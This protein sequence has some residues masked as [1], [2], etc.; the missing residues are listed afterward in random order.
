MFIKG[1]HQ[2][3]IDTCI[4]ALH[5]G[6]LIKEQLELSGMK[7]TEFA[8]R[9]NKTSQNVYA[10]LERT[11]IDSVLLANISEILNFNFFEALAMEIDHK[12]GVL[13]RYKENLVENQSKNV[14]AAELNRC[15]QESKMQLLKIAQLEKEIE[16]LKEINLLLR[17]KK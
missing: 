8:R 15:Q 11:S 4:M 13:P 5:I 12:R 14:L 1:K 7:K 10:I 6:H 3:Y 17:E 16:Y 2:F 9:I